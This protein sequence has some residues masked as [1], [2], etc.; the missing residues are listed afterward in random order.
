[1]IIIDDLRPALGAFNTSY[2][3]TPNIDQLASQ[4]TLY[5]RTYAQQA[6]CGPSRTSFLTGRRPD[7]I[8]LY[9][10]H[11]YWRRAAGNFTTLPQYFKE[12]GYHTLSIG[13]IFH[14]GIVSNHSDDC[15]YSWSEKPYHPPTLKYRMSKVCPTKWGK[16]M[17]IV[18]PVDVESQ[19]GKSLPDIE[20]ADYSVRFLNNYKKEKPFFMAVGFHK[21]HIP[22]KFP[23]EYL[24]LYPFYRIPKLK[25]ATKPEKLPLPAWNPWNDLRL[26]DDI[27]QLN[28]TFPFEEIPLNYRQKIRQSYFASTSYMDSQVGR[29]LSALTE[30]GFAEN[31]VILF[32]SDHGWSLGE[33]G[34]WSKFSNF[35]VSTRV[36][37]LLHL[38]SEGSFK[39]NF[40]D[41]LKTPNR[42]TY[43]PKRVSNELVELVDVFPTL[44]DVV[45]LEPLRRCR[46]GHF[47]KV[48]TEGLS[49]LKRQTMNKIAAFSQYPRPSI[50]P[51][52]DSDQPKLRY[53]R[54]MGYSVRTAKYRYTEWVGF[55]PLSFKVDWTRVYGREL[56]IHSN[57]DDSE[58]CNKA[59]D[60]ESE[61][62]MLQ[63]SNLLKCGYRCSIRPY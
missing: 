37:L 56:Y 29:V 41:A 53:I 25:D 15:P 22:L 6:L 50:Y 52:F 23:K 38:P 11:S 60:E 5:N 28:L 33:H 48:C 16:R 45:G 31:T 30:N 9:D 63:L 55:N 2:M 7:S 20:I 35:E 17:N 4:S 44:V 12:K 18:C 1:M 36:P 57:N 39:F 19:P 43:T 24:D 8:K 32:M 3:N 27:Q 13:K 10:V 59:Y 49:L 26:R 51:R 42:L 61:L 46:E 58:D 47:E 34:E 62:I 54:I 14:P 40:V 21:P